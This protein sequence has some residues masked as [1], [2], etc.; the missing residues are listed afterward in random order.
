V[1]QQLLPVVV[2]FVLTGV[3]GTFLGYQLQNRAWAHQ[4]EV[5]RHDEERRKDAA[6]VLG[7]Y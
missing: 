2:G 3:I 6:R 1:A 7:G 4:H 5:Q